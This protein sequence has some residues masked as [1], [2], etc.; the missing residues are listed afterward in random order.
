MR[1]TGD[2]KQWAMA[3]VEIAS[4]GIGQSDSGVAFGT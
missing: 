1:N 4:V 2:A 3:A